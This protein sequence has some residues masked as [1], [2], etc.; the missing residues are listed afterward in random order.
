MR[1]AIFV[2]KAKAHLIA[3]VNITTEATGLGHVLGNKGG[4]VTSLSWRDTSLCFV[5]S[6]LAA[7]QNKCA[8]RNDNFKEIVEGC[9]IGVK[10]MDILN[11]FHHVI[12][13]GDL[14]YR[15]DYGDQ[16]A[17]ET[18]SQET[19]DALVAEINAEPSKLH[20]LFTSCDQLRKEMLE[21]RVFKGFTDLEP[22]FKPT[23]K[24]GRT[25]D[26]EYKAQRSPAWCDRVLYQSLMPASFKLTPLGFHS[27]NTIG[28][29][30]HKP[31]RADFLVEVFDLPSGFDDTKGPCTIQ[32][33]NVAAANLLAADANG[34][35]DPYV[36]FVGPCIKDGS[37][38]SKHISNV[39]ESR[40]R[41]RGWGCA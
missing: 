33:R 3:N 28:T 18:P 14:N 26:L 21:G 17:K 13:M 8:A 24:V 12:W 2:V 20:D 38:K 25:A 37:F 27:A 39:R 1:L 9:E 29:S 10:P 6:H 40:K 30:D 4:V 15:L 19:F 31:V 5:N 32:F 11:Q 41:W 7:H 36:E 34:L 16:G 23:F 35:S 22:T